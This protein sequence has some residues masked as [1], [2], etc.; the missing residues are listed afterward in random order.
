MIITNILYAIILGKAT[1]I[2][3]SEGTGLDLGVL[4]YSFLT[5]K[6]FFFPKILHITP[7]TELL[8]LL[9]PLAPSRTPQYSL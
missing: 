3:F 8:C 6:A 1:V 4:R 2:P 9:F 7:Q 5:A